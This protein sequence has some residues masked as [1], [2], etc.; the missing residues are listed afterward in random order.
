MRPSRYENISKSTLLQIYDLLH[1]FEM[2]ECRRQNKDTVL[3]YY[4]RTFKKRK[5]SAEGRARARLFDRVKLTL[6]DLGIPFEWGFTPRGRNSKE[7][8]FQIPQAGRHK[9]RV[10]R[11]LDLC[12]Q[13]KS[14]GWV[15]GPILGHPSSV[16]N[17]PAS[18][19]PSTLY[20]SFSA[21]F[22]HEQ[23]TLEQF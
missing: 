21:Q 20:A 23:E 12:D 22:S 13:T 4:Y 19:F 18:E 10:S 16:G 3:D 6:R 17:L 5:N 15:P 14:R 2:N 9:Q 1:F 7:P 11:M 8:W